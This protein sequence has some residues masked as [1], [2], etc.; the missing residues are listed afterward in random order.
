MRE[1]LEIV[2]SW[3]WSV[4]IVATALKPF[5]KHLLVIIERFFLRRPPGG[6]PR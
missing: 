3:V 5:R 2:P 6:P 1:V 4:A